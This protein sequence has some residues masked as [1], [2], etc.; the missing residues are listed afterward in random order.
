MC[1]TTNGFALV[2]LKKR[3]TPKIVEIFIL[4]LGVIVWKPPMFGVCPLFTP[5]F[6]NS[7]LHPNVWGLSSFHPN[8]SK[9]PPPPQCLG[10][11]I[12]SP[13]TLLSRR[14][15]S[16]MDATAAAD[17]TRK[18]RRCHVSTRQ[19]KKS[20]FP[21]RYGRKRELWIFLFFPLSSPRFL[22]FLPSLFFLFFPLSSPRFL[23]LLPSLFFLLSSPRLLFFFSSPRLLFF[24]SSPRLLFFFSSPRLLFFFSSPRLLFFFSSP[25]LIFFFSYPRLLFFLYLP[26]LLL[27]ASACRILPWNNQV[28]TKHRTYRCPS[29]FCS[30]AM[31]GH[32]CSIAEVLSRSLS[33]NKN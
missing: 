2:T 20:D 22:F 13:P 23:F 30:S 14:G 1:Q 10:F 15:G 18:P 17:R 31:W 5:M 3:I 4:N 11:V 29:L 21:L 26:C 9:Q 12:F 25:R 6:Q 19:N 7:R 27:S 32:H 8:V 28:C 33:R 24:F 16:D